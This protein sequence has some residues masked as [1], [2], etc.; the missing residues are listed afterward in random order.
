MPSLSRD[1]PPNRRLFNCFATSKGIVIGYVLG[2]VTIQFFALELESL[3]VCDFKN[4][5]TSENKILKYESLADSFSKTSPTKPK[6]DRI[7]CWVITSPKTHH[8]A[9]LVSETWGKRCDKLLFMSSIQGNHY[10]KTYRVRT[11]CYMM[12][13]VFFSYQ[14]T[15]RKDQTMPEAIVLPILNDTY[16]NLW[17]KTQEALKYLYVHHLHDA[18]WF[19]KADDDT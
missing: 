10:V 9:R 4:N 3:K 7:L 5:F 1:V 14:L 6:R 17:G 2:I 18:D 16:A 12:P 15:L 19:Y 11:T 13:K 8:R